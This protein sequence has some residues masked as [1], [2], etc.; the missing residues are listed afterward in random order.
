MTA[1][2]VLI[3]AYDRHG[4]L[5]LRQRQS[6]SADRLSLTIGS[7]ATADVIVDDTDVAALHARLAI[8]ADG[9]LVLTDLGAPKGILVAGTR[10]R[11]TEVALTGNGFEVGGTRMVATLVATH[12]FETSPLVPAKAPIWLVCA[13]VVVLL[14][15]VVFDVWASFPVDWPVT[16]LTQVS[17]FAL[18]WAIW[19]FLWARHT[20]RNFGEIRLAHH[21]VI[22]F[23]T[24]LVG[25]ALA[26]AADLTSFAFA[27]PAVGR[28]D[29]VWVF[30]L[31]CIGIYLHLGIARRTS[32][33]RRMLVA[34]AVPLVLALAYGW[35]QSRSWYSDVN[36][37]A[38]E[39]RLYPWVFKIVA[40]VQPLAFFAEAEKLR[41]KA[42]E[43]MKKVPQR[44][45][46]QFEV[47]L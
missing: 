26:N 12:P 37:I 11:G 39:Q 17:L 40:P 7:G 29:M 23:G 28:Y 8:A 31:V 4:Q 32:S 19:L 35:V 38:S 42:D 13:L 2:V 10:Y 46:E 18:L 1:P 36:S 45:L 21:A 9:Q 41:A 22:G 33:T 47:D 20:R 44:V 30:G 34:F 3:E 5:L 16:L 27:L 43:A 24:A 15:K 14:A 25:D 6:I